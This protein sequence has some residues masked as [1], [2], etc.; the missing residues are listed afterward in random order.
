LEFLLQGE[1]TGNRFEILIMAAFRQLS[2]TLLSPASLGLRTFASTASSLGKPKILKTDIN[3]KLPITTERLKN[4]VQFVDTPE[5]SEATLIK[6]V[7]DADIILTCY[8]RVT[9]KVIDA[10]KNL[11]AIIKYGVG[12]DAID[13]QY[14]R[15]K[16]IPVVNVPLYAEN[17]VA[18]GAFYLM[19]RVL[20]RG[21]FIESDLLKHKWLEPEEK[22][23]NYDLAGKT[24]GIIGL[25]RIGTSTARMATAFQMNVIAYDPYVSA[26]TMSSKG[27]KKVDKLEDLMSTADIVTLHATLTHENSHMVNQAML[28]K[29]KSTAY[30]INSARGE[31]VDEKALVK[32]VLANKIAGV[33]IDVYAVE[34]IDQT[35]YGPLYGRHNAILWPHLTFFTLE[36]M[37]RLEIDTIE[38]I[39]EIISKQP[40][41]IKS[42]NPLL[43][44]QK[45]TKE[46]I[47]P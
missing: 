2:R 43:L 47:V 18:E 34:P 26:A 23:L 1:K 12:I 24:I 41:T 37:E 8:A 5:D 17:T 28:D 14:A 39:E 13:V 42:R 10:A 25:G 44:G 45:G 46:V 7:A 27:A 16:N 22:Y 3:L 30:L 9:P 21:S 29:M 15:K 33:G 35:L 11:K 4:V 31:L 6:S 38:R 20:K 36:A 32:H 40:I 19:M